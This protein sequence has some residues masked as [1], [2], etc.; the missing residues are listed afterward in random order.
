MLVFREVAVLAITFNRMVINL[1]KRMG[2]VKPSK[3]YV[4][5][6]LS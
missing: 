5:A 2:E 1:E 4:N 6:L 3:K